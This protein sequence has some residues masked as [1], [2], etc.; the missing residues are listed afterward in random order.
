VVLLGVAGAVV[1]L[2]F[3]QRVWNDGWG[4]YVT[5]FIWAAAMA[6]VVP[7]WGAAVV[8]RQF[9]ASLLIGWAGGGV[10]IV[11]YRAVLLDHLRAEGISDV[12]S[13]LIVVFGLILLALLVVA[14]LLVRA[15]PTSQAEH[16]TRG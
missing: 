7:A 10:A 8:P 6:L 12:G 5:Q 13:E 9:G 3:A 4:W 15:D 16:A 1:M 11:I 14:A 2:L